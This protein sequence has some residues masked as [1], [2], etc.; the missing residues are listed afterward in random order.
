MSFAN[1][2]LTDISNVVV[3]FTNNKITKDSF[4]EFLNNWNHVI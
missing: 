4:N 1:F 2:D 3:T